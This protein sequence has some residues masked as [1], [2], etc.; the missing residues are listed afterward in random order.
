MGDPRQ[1]HRRWPAPTQAGRPW[2]VA[3]GITNPPTP[4]KASDESDSTHPTR[5][6]RRGPASRTDQEPDR[7]LADHGHRRRDRR[8]RD[9]HRVVRHPPESCGSNVERSGSSRREREHVQPGAKSCHRRDADEHADDAGSKRYQR[10]QR[11]QR[12]DKFEYLVSGISPWS[13]I[14]SQGI[15]RLR[16]GHAQARGRHCRC[17]KTARP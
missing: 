16:A 4:R 13:A 3:K 1:L 12:R 11:Q 8:A 2:W 10:G 17:G 6:S 14:A 7:E 9:L 15:P 5:S